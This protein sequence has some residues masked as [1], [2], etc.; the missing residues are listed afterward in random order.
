VTRTIINFRNV[1]FIEQH[2]KLKRAWLLHYRTMLAAIG[3]REFGNAPA[4]DGE[5][6]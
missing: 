6:P 4:L 3:D 1:S 5:K 2:P